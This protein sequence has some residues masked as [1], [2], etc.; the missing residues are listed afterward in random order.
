MQSSMLPAATVAARAPSAAPAAAP[1]R[2]N[3]NLLMDTVQGRVVL[4]DA[5][6]AQVEA[7]SRP[8]RKAAELTRAPSARVN[9]RVRTANAQGGGSAASC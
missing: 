9:A 8:K 2:A 6:V 4:A 3:R 7:A 5:L 1:A